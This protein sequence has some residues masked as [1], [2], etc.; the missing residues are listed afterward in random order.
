MVPFIPLP[1]VSTDGDTTVFL[2][3]YGG[4]V[5]LVFGFIGITLVQMAML[6]WRHCRGNHIAFRQLTPVIAGIAANYIYDKLKK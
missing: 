3:R 4:Q 5:L 6:I 1:E 2:Y